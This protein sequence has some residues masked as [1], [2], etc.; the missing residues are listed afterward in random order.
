MA[1]NKAYYYIKLKES[2]FDQDNIK[3]LESLDNGYIYS[4]ILI[5]LYLKA[6]KSNGR[7]M[8]TS[9]IPYNPEKVEILSKVIGHDVAHVKEA[10]RAGVE[11]DLMTIIDGREIWLN[12]IQNFIGQSSTEADRK[13]LYR[14]KLTKK[15]EI[16]QMSGQISDKNPPELE[17]ELE[18]DIEKKE[19]NKEKNQKK[20]ENSKT[21]QKT[22]KEI[23]SFLFTQFKEICVSLPQP[24]DLTNKRK[25]AMRAR[26]KEF[27]QKQIVEVF[28]RVEASD[29]L[30]RRSSN[31][32]SW[33]GA[34]FDWIFNQ[35]NFLKILEGNYDNKSSPGKNQVNFHR[36]G[37]SNDVK[38]LLKDGF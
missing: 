3:I 25:S 21:S 10:I 32:G 5:K 6:S 13:R 14:K 15:L 37:T 35:T 12:D 8:M 2:Y 7:L 17:I 9:T 28:R 20:I 31:N 1:D 11:L 4:L 38:E 33:P 29:F 36:Y 19:I 27:N 22:E 34:T 24:R 30:T 23:F 26:L 18:I 16:G